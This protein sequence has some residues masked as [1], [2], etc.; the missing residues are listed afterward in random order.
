MAEYHRERHTIDLVSF[1]GPIDRLRSQSEAFHS[2]YVSG[3]PYPHLAVENLFDPD[4]L[5]RLAAEFPKSEERDW[6]TWD[7]KNELKTTSRGIK[8]LPPFTQLFCLW[9]NSH[10]F[11]GE[12]ERITGIDNLVGDPTFYG[13]GLHEMF[14]GGWLSMHTDFTSHPSLSLTRCVNLLIYLNRD[15]DADWGGELELWDKN[16]QG[17]RVAYP[18]FFNQTVILPTNSE[19]F[20]HGAPRRISCPDGYSR[21]LVSI[22]YWTPLF[23]TQSGGKPWVTWADDD[24]LE[25]LKRMKRRAQWIWEAATKKMV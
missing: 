4:D 16:N 3:S 20:Y 24:K 14:K 12:I 2:N 21:K 18:P 23:S 22:Y 19:T 15:W 6:L 5:D 9:L 13:A 25:I 11:I 1:T 17:K 8:K 7:H 10:E